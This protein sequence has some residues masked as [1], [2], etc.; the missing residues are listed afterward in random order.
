M[1]RL[2]VGWLSFNVIT[3]HL[4]TVVYDKMSMTRD[5]PAYVIVLLN[6][7]SQGHVCILPYHIYVIH[8]V[9]WKWISTMNI[10]LKD[11]GLKNWKCKAYITP[12]RKIPGIG[13]WRWAMPPTPEFCIGDTNMLVSKL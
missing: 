3:R 1:V 5:A 13:G 9:Q 7:I 4:L 11:G 10:S 8:L 2:D 12:K 6:V